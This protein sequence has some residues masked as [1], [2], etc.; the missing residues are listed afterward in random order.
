MRDRTR[1]DVDTWWRAVFEVQDGLWSTRT[2]LHPHGLLDDYEGWYVAWRGDGVHVSAPSAATPHDVALLR[3]QPIPTLQEPAFWQTFAHEHG[4]QLLGPST[5][6]YIDLD[7]G[8]SRD[9][10]ALHADHLNDLETRVR[11]EE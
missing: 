4:M 9:V 1:L 7:P 6:F 3:T 5:H 8:P 10:V 11:R 2:V